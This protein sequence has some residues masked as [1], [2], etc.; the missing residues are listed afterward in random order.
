[1]LAKALH[2]QAEL[3]L[4]ARLQDLSGH[5]IAHNSLEQWA[6]LGVTQHEDCHVRITALSR[7]DS[8]GHKVKIVSI[9]VSSISAKA[10]PWLRELSSKNSQGFLKGL[11]NYT[12]V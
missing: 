1:M 2:P 8:D 6:Y 7:T 5:H 10:S 9:L 11:Y 3:V 4:P 12:G